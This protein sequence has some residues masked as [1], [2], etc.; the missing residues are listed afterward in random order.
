MPQ[1]RQQVCLLLEASHD[2]AARQ[3][4][5]QHLHRHGTV[6]SPLAAF[7]NTPHAPFGQHPDDRHAAEIA[8][9]RQFDD[10]LAVEAE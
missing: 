4:V 9:G 10:L 6:G 7:I 2:R 1:P 8:A 5:A 3:P